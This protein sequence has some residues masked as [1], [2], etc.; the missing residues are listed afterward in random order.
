LNKK[1][2]I[3][4]EIK[5]MSIK[6]K[7]TNNEINNLKIKDKLHIYTYKVVIEKDNK[8]LFGS[9]QDNYQFQS[10]M[11][12]NISNLI[13]QQSKISYYAGFHSYSNFFPALIEKI[14][15]NIKDYRKKQRYRIIKCK[16]PTDSIT[17]VLKNNWNFLIIIS[18][19]III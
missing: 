18:S 4:I 6:Y 16:I 3:N 14:R 1:R 11:N 12:K 8:H 2:N 7:L 5:I 15:L 10:G 9:Y 17:T 13:I 19:E